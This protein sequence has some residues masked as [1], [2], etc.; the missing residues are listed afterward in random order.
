MGG[1]N[2]KV[3]VSAK[4]GRGRGVT[5]VSSPEEQGDTGF[6]SSVS[7]VDVFNDRG[8]PCFPSSSPKSTYV[9]PEI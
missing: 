5:P 4:T 3:P 8:S 1:G 6:I 7:R 9:S 2:N